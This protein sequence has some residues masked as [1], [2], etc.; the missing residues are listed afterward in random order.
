MMTVGQLIDKLRDYPNDYIVLMSKDA[1]GN[2]FHQVDEAV[3]MEPDP[4]GNSMDT[5]VLWPGRLYRD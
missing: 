4:E 3:G 5:V 2:V 1:E